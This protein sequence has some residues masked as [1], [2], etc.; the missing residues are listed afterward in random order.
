M[1][2]TLDIKTARADGIERMPSEPAAC[3]DWD[4]ERKKEGSAIIL[5][6]LTNEKH[7]VYETPPFKKYEEDNTKQ[8]TCLIMIDSSSNL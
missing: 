7:G 4:E 1:Q 8:I 5:Y 6:T 3:F 2:P